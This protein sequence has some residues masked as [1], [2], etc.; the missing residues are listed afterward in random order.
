MAGEPR[1]PGTPV[2]DRGALAAIL[3]AALPFLALLASCGGKPPEVAAVEWRLEL[4]PSKEG[5]YESLSAFASI[6]DEDGIEDLDT[7]WV[8][9]DGSAL[10]WPLT[11]SDWTRRAE[12][13]DTW[14]GASGL[15]RNDY[16]PMPRGEYRLVAID[17]AGERVEKAFRVEGSFPGIAAPEVFFEGG[18]LR[19]A[20]A[21]PETLIL[22]FDG[23]GGLLASAAYAGSAEGLPEL[24][25]Q[26]AAAR[27]AEVAAYGYDP[28][29]KMGAYSWK[30]KTR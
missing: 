13:A 8:L 17:A 6:K 27:T 14:I 18:K 12:G 2:E 30:K 11:N 24:F 26:E 15:A 29:R 19:A 5:A 23:A 7:L 22:A 21:W 9:H 16:G 25:G 10:A 4:R 20:S 3:F 28:T 1:S